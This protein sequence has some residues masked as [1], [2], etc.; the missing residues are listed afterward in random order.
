[1]S[2]SQYEGPSPDGYLAGPYDRLAEACRAA[3]HTTPHN[4][5]LWFLTPGGFRKRTHGCNGQ[6]SGHQCLVGR[7]NRLAISP[8]LSWSAVSGFSLV[9]TG[10]GFGSFGRVTRAADE[11]VVAASVAGTH[12]SDGGTR[13]GAA[14][15]RAATAVFG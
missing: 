14:D 12:S 4:P 10:V 6:W 2:N 1:M 3:V 5:Y 13:T 11:G 15:W 7:P 9:S 8:G